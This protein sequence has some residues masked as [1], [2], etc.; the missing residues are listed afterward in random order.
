MTDNNI[1]VLVDLIS[2]GKNAEASDL[3]N[4]EMLTRSYEK[5]DSLR[6]KIAKNYFAPVIDMSTQTG[7]VT[8]IE[9]N[10]EAEEE[11]DEE[12]ET[13]EET[14]EEEPEE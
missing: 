7:E 8:T 9:A 12:G 10:S 11:T 5:V 14:P 4:V 3:L 1:A 13:T 6:P 2:Q